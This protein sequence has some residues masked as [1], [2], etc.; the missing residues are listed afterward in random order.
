MGGEDVEGL[1]LLEFFDSFEGVE[2]FF[3]A[4]DGDVFA[5]FEGEG[6]EDDGKGATALF[7]L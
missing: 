2:A 4:L 6:G 7:V 1:Y 5:V 3:H